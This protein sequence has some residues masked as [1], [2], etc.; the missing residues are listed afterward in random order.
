VTAPSTEELTPR[1]DWDRPRPAAAPHP[2]GATGSSDPESETLP[3]EPVLPEAP[4]RRTWRER[5]PWGP[6]GSVTAWVAAIALLAVSA[7]VAWA[8]IQPQLSKPYV[9]DEA[10]FAFAGKAVAQTGIPLS[11]VGHMQFETAGD[12]SKRFNWALWHPPL[13]V[14]T[15]G[16]AFKQF[17]ESEQ[18]A[19]MV[20]VVCNALAALFAFG[21]ATLALHG[22]TRAAPLYAAA[23]T[24]FYVTNPFVIQ[25]ALLLDIDGTV[26]VAS[27]ALLGLLYTALLKLPSGIRSPWTWL[28]MGLTACAF[29]LS[30]WAKM[31]TAFALPVAALL[32]RL[33]ATRPWRPLRALIEV[34]LIAGVGGGLFLGTWWLACL[35][36]GMPFDAPFRI[37]AIELHDATGAAASLDQKA[38]EL[39]DHLV[40]VALWVSPYLI[41]LFV[42]A[43]VA[44]L[45]DL[46]SGPFVVGAHRLLK[47]P[48]T[49]E[50]WGAWAVDF[51]LVCGGAIGFAY[52][53]KL[54][55]S[56]P[57]YHI[58]MMP[59]WAVGMAYLLFRY[60]KRIAW[61]EPAVY[62]V[63]TAGMSGY[64]VSFVGDKY[65]LFSG[66]TFTLPLLVWP[67]ALGFAFLVLCVALGRNNLPRQ[68]AI[69]GALLTLSWSW[70]VN[71]AQS[72]ADYSTA[73]NYGSF[74]QQKTAARLNALA[75][76]RQPFIASRD[77]AYYTTSQNYVDQDTFWEHIAR[78][79]A[80]GIKTFDGSIAGYP[81]VDIA[82]LFLWDP[83]LGRIAHSYLADLY[84]V[85]FQEGPFLIF[86]RTAP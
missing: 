10:A 28:L 31:T 64:F 34:P 6:L 11:N 15:L 72:R 25:S 59:F 12:F 51:S 61:W 43:G 83:E 14:F 2:T 71:L 20:G 4:R 19:R 16:W 3:Y 50:P 40:Y 44:R 55:A 47:R 38:R 56:F 65:V 48:L 30:M 81:R 49:R 7:T 74:G 68:L 33:F 37:L 1:S 13:Y 77:V 82:A 80:A 17:G 36:T 35:L 9:Y 79:D 75:D 5:V 29:G 46:V 84:E 32:Y 85:D 8:L 39:F 63:V 73:Y 58:S 57:K 45:V 18:T 21:T 60:V 22:R 86:I 62:A 70:G 54:A 24:A 76:P 53:I 26:L 69:L 41:A 42:W 78:L 66:Y 52:L 67:A 27:I 23:G